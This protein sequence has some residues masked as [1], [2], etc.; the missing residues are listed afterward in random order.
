MEQGGL[1]HEKR[2]NRPAVKRAEN[3]SLHDQ[4]TFQESPCGSIAGNRS[5]HDQYRL[6]L[7]WFASLPKRAGN[8]FDS[9]TK[10]QKNLT[11]GVRFFCICRGAGNRTRTTRSQTAYTTT[12]LHPE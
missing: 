2:W 5:L 3:R 11:A 10:I 8:L 9:L 4:Y 7:F 1:F 6:S 12:M